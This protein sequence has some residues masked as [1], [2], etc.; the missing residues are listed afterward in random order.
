M[1]EKFLHPHTNFLTVAIHYIHIMCL[2]WLSSSESSHFN[3]HS[4]EKKGKRD[5]E[6]EKKWKKVFIYAD[7]LVWSTLSKEMCL[8]LCLS[9]ARFCPTNEMRVHGFL[10]AARSCRRRRGSANQRRWL[11][12]RPVRGAR[13]L[14]GR[15]GWGPW[16][17]GRRLRR[18]RTKAGLM[19]F[20]FQAEGG[21]GRRHARVAW[22]LVV[23]VHG[24][25]CGGGVGGGG[26]GGGRAE[27]GRDGGH[28]G[29]DGAV[30]TAGRL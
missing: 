30:H 27:G 22:V 12:N 1:F 28:A 6:R 2:R 16:W 10:F 11:E 5:R 24:V 29:H 13:V 26:G 23:L 7:P 20:G 17:K 25:G 4:A 21:Y 14:A 8:T 18:I 9:L 3:C 19:L 15:Q